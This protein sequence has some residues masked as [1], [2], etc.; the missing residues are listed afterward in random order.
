LRDIR[1]SIDNDPPAG[2]A[3]DELRASGE[4]VALSDARLRDR[5]AKPGLSRPIEYRAASHPGVYFLEPYSPDKIPVLFVHGINGSPANFAHLLAHLDRSRFQ[6]W[7]YAYPSG[8]HLDA[9]TDYLERSM[10][11]LH[12]RYRYE[13]VAV[14]GHSM[15]GLVARGFILRHARAAGID[16]IPLFVSLSTPWGGHG[17][18]EFAVKY[19]PVVVD[20]WRDMA[21]GSAYLE[22][23]FAAR[24]PD[25]TRHYLVFTFNRKKTSFGDSSDRR[26]SVA[27]QLSAPAQREAVRV[28]GFDDTHDGVLRDSAVA[29][30][31]NELLDAT[32]PRS[33]QNEAVANIRAPP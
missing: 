15:G 16:S 33:A 22:D 13:S 3:A 24:L 14:I 31:I 10:A 28:V 26:V 1:N 30:L 8:A 2:W 17:A 6:P 29:S 9:V 19:S 27:S 5:I 20:V 11:S 12:A 23:L 4:V 18:A 21:P 32:F 7:L 25:A